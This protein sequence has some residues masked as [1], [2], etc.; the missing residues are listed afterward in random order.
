MAGAIATIAVFGA[1]VITGFIRFA[2]AVSAFGAFTGQAEA[3]LAMLFQHIAIF[4][5]FAWFAADIVFAKKAGF[6]IL[7]FGAAATFYAVVLGIRLWIF[8]AGHR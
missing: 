2:P 7:I 1:A 3:L 8:V 6:A 5:A 4:M